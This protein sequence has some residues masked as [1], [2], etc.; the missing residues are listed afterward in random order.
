MADIPAM[1]DHYVNNLGL[2]MELPVG[3]NAT[4]E[5]PAFTFLLLAPEESDYSANLGFNLNYLEPPT[6][7]TLDE[8]YEIATNEQATYPEYY[9]SHHEVLDIDGN[10]THLWKYEWA[11]NGMHFSQIQ[12]IMFH[13]PIGAMYVLSGASLKQHENKYIPILEYVIRNLWVVLPQQ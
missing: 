5:N 4:T 1:I 10:P 6:L 9:Q 7:E 12:A 13:E 2:S 3:W 8:Q 11:E